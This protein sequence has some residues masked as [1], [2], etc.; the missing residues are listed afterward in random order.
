L[1]KEKIKRKTKI[2]L[3]TKKTGNT[4]YKNMK[5]A[6]LNWKFIVTNAYM[7]IKERSQTT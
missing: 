1:V 2:Y 5:K 4:I 6:A 3:E 7:R